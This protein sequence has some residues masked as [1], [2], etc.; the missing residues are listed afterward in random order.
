MK[1]KNMHIKFLFQIS[2]TIFP[3]SQIETRL[4][5]K[6]TGVFYRDTVFVSTNNKGEF[7]NRVE[8][9][10]VKEVLPGFLKYLKEHDSNG[11]R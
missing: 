7:V 4:T 1:L 5:Y 11:N 3:I 10:N 8:R 2:K 9:I 6:R